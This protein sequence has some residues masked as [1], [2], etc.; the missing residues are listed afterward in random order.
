MN[1]IQNRKTAL[2]TGANRGLGLEV[3]KELSDRGYTVLLTGR[4]SEAVRAAAGALAEQGL[5]VRAEELDVSQDSSI[6]A[7]VERLRTERVALDLLVNNAAITM[8]GFN[9]VVARRTIDTNFYG[10]MRV[11]DALL[12]LMPDGAT[13]VMVSSGAGELSILEPQLRSRFSDPALTRE[14]LQ[15]LV[16]SFVE[17][18]RLKRHTARG[19]PPSAYGVSKASLNALVRL[20]A[21]E[22]APR[23][24]RVNAVCPGW[25]RT[26]M[27]GPGASRSVQEGAA[28]ILQATLLE[29]DST[30]GFFR[31]GR[32]IAW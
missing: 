24:I 15:T 3:A 2:V 19:W 6:G 17:D 9:A 28:S 23:R 7:L 27:G 21:R 30:G 26:D 4:Q 32:P 25:V 8:D 13:I 5:A 18:V 12:Q 22:L 29:G 11:T 10:P 14:G 31:D 1:T 16:E 20:L